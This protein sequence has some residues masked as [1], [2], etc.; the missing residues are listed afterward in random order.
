MIAVFGM[1]PVQTLVTDTG[2]PTTATDKNVSALELDKGLGPSVIFLDMR[3]D[4]WRAPKT[5][6]CRPPTVLETLSGVTATA[7]GL[8]VASKLYNIRFTSIITMTNCW[9]DA[10]H[11]R[12]SL[13]LLYTMVPEL[14][15]ELLPWLHSP[16]HFGWLGCEEM[17]LEEKKNSATRE[18]LRLCERLHR[19][20][21]LPVRYSVEDIY[22]SWYLKC[23]LDLHESGEAQ[24]IAERKV[25]DHLWSTGAEWAAGFDV[26]YIPPTKP[27]APLKKPR[28]PPKPKTAAY[29]Y[30]PAVPVAPNDVK[31][32]VKDTLD[33]R[34]EFCN[35]IH[36][37]Q[38]ALKQHR[39]REHGD[40]LGVP[41]KKRAKKS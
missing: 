23:A 38:P 39:T 28:A 34:C 5:D 30:K 1:C 21:I 31:S 32:I 33:F 9:N 13:R 26:P 37:S 7:M 20:K 22:E 2:A 27:R 11:E 3:K 24:D 17:N 8:L 10:S 25:P 12:S 29:D 19:C 36:M 14:G 15:L 40:R 41:P 16:K 35:S 18:I 6:H 4:C